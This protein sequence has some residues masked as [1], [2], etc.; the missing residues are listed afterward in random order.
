MPV[1]PPNDLFFCGCRLI[2]SR[3]R[4]DVR[5]VYCGGITLPPL[6]QYLGGQ[7]RFQRHIFENNDLLYV[8]ESTAVSHART[9]SGVVAMLVTSLRL[10]AGQLKRSS[11]LQPVVLLLGSHRGT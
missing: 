5:R 6:S 11:D 1:Y 7:S 8:Q 2:V 9:S 4:C 10:Y 3:F